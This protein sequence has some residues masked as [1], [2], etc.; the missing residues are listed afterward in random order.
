MEHKFEKV[1]EIRAVL[2]WLDPRWPWSELTCL[3]V[4]TFTDDSC[5]IRPETFIKEANRV[6]FDFMLPLTSFLPLY[7]IAHNPCL[8]PSLDWCW[9]EA[10]KM[11]FPQFLAM[12]VVADA[13][14]IVVTCW[15][16]QSNFSKTQTRCEVRGVRLSVFVRWDLSNRILNTRRWRDFSRSVR[17]PRCRLHF[18]YSWHNKQRCHSV[19]RAADI[20]EKWTEP[21]A[22]CIMM[23]LKD[24]QRKYSA[25]YVLMMT[26]TVPVLF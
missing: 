7:H 13:T 1:L 3:D 6:H 2:E 18:K 26:V 9:G 12:C 23:L 20:I 22:V 10:M 11:I 5:R 19:S 21:Y 14:T 4:I 17:F 24:L 15:E 25:F 8:F 16:A